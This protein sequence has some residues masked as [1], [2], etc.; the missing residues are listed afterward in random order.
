MS[1]VVLARKYRPQSF[2]D[3]VGQGHVSTTLENAI[4]KNR[5][6]HAFLFTGVRGVG[7]TTSARILAKSLNCVKGPTA[8]P[9]QECAPCKEITVGSDVDVQ[10]IDGASYTGVDDVRKLQESLPYRPSR[11]RFKIFIVDEVHMLS[12][13][14]WNAFLKTLEEP[15]PHVKFI[16]ATTEVHKIPVTI[17]SRCQRYDFKLISAL[18]ITARLRFVLDREG[19][20]YE[21]AALS[22]I[23]RE[24]AGSMRDAMSLLDQVLAWVGVDG[25]KLT[26]EG[27][28]RVLGV[29]DRSVLHG[30][31][32]ALVDGDPEACL[33]TVSD[34]AHQGYDLPH[35]ARDFLAHLRDL[36]VAKVSADP[37]GLLDLA[38]SELADVKALAARA[39]A[40][41]LT[42]LH[43][44][45]SRSF[46]DITRSGQ[47]RAALEMALVRLSRRPPLMPVDDLL[48]RL[49]EMERRLLGSGGGGS[50]GASGA[51]QGRPMQGGGSPPA[52]RRASGSE[53]SSPSPSP[54]AS[55]P[56]PPPGA[57]AAP[58]FSPPA[59]APSRVAPA[60]SQAAPAFSPPAPAPSRVAPASSQAAPTFSP[61]ASAFSP[62][63]SASSQAAPA[64]SRVSSASS[65]P[66]PANG[67]SYTNGA[68]YTNGA[69]PPGRPAAPNPADVAAFRAV[70]ELVRAKRAPLGSVLEHAALL[71]IGPDGIV[72][73]YEGDSFLG[74]QAQD[75]VAKE[76][77][78]AALAAHFGGT[79]D[80]TFETLRPQSGVVTLAQLDGADRRARLDSARRAIADHP[81]VT[82]AIELLGAELRDVRLGHEDAVAAERMSTR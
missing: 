63:A 70:I 41:D 2:E 58:A 31:A 54:S 72:L 79:P 65:R 39:D 42:R 78:R 82:A 25:D 73:G 18:S 64:P 52:Q 6:A 16:F 15:P 71:R 26:A 36:V 24:A 1:Y 81:L 59:P 53:A 20:A 7:K 8:K 27:V 67:A 32:A 5:V 3:L 19:V 76:A 60:S 30:L 80:V 66:P 57:Q 62:P 10:E 14:A 68:P 51:G 46:D 44:G 4:A 29:A 48:R 13:N 56:V 34:L 75:P 50:H 77:L 28:A 23:A 37:T 40:D 61:P 74:K 43:Q 38:D 12:N 9:C 45:F 47:P 69:A 17:L 22:I 35:V 49:G 21:D 55:S 33:R 11:D